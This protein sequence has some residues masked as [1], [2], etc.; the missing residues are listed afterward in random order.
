MI[1]TKQKQRNMRLFIDA[2]I[3]LILEEGYDNVSIRKIGDKALFNSATIYNYF[4]N[5]DHLKSIAAVG[6]IENYILE[7]EPIVDESKSS[8]DLLRNVWR[9][10]LSNVYKDPKTFQ[11]LFARKK[12]KYTNSNMNEYYELY[13]EKLDIMPEVLNGMLLASDLKS[14]SMYLLSPCAKDKFFKEVDLIDIDNQ[15]QYVFYGLLNDLMIEKELS[16][17]EYMRRADSYTENIINSYL[18]R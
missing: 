16:Y 1:K 2:T 7:L 14:R 10:F 11:I 15:L 18:L 8:L 6:L 17:D 4:K 13:P 9:V 3:E 12:G 5:I